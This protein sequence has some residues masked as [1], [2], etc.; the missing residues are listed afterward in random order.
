MSDSRTLSFG[1]TR[2][3]QS[4]PFSTDRGVNSSRVH[5]RATNAEQGDAGLIRLAKKGDVDAFRELVE[6]YQQRV[7]A[8]AFGVVGSHEDADDVV[9]EAFLKAYR[10]LH[11]FRGQSSFY[12]WLYRIVFNLS[13]DLSR[14]RY[15]HVEASV[16]DMRSLEVASAAT[17]DDSQ[18]AS[19]AEDVYRRKE[20]RIKI[21]EAI[22]S[23]SPDHRAVI[24]LREIDGLSYTE[25]SDAVGCSKGTVMSRLHHARRK[26]QNVLRGFVS[27]DAP[28]PGENSL[29][30]GPKGD[31]SS[32]A[33]GKHGNQVKFVKESTR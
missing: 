32:E 28:A 27:E 19:S 14:K 3:L 5:T 1:A 26:L 30:P 18:E 15:R 31:K 8:I 33:S 6:K 16:G 29:T 7:H 11:L 20:L 25:I 9:Q 21:S 13:I 23:L 22:K 17:S 2:L 24:I 10:N 12:T 4:A